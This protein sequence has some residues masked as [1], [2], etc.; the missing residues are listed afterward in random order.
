[1]SPRTVT[2]RDGSDRFMISNRHWPAADWR[3]E[4][5]NVCLELVRSHPDGRANQLDTSLLHGFQCMPSISPSIGVDQVVAALAEQHQ[6]VDR[7]DVIRIGRRVGPCAVLVEGDDMRY[8]CIVPPARGPP[9]EL[10]AGFAP[11]GRF[12]RLYGGDRHVM[13][14]PVG[15]EKPHLV[16]VDVGTGQPLTPQ[17]MR[18]VSS[19]SWSTRPPVDAFQGLEIRRR[20]GDSPTVGLRPPFGLSP[21]HHSHAD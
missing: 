14:V 20:G 9:A 6:V 8:I 19:L 4:Q 13:G 1:M 3:L 15:H 10:H 2:W 17:N 11:D 16:V 7:V 18:Q 21:P 5:Q 12:A